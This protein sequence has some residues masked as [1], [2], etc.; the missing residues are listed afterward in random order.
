MPQLAL[1]TGHYRCH[2]CAREVECVRP[3]HPRTR[4]A[5]FVVVAFCCRTRIEHQ[6]SVFKLVASGD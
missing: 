2:N 6:M 4:R 3:A 5:G 1:F